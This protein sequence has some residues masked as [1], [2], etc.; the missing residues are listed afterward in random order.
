MRVE[1]VFLEFVQAQ[2]SLESHG[3]VLGVLSFVGLEKKTW[4]SNLSGCPYNFN[5]KSARQD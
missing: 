4:F 1:K 5:H 3:V 2:A